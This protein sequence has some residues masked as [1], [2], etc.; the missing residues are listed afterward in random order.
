MR[1]SS[2]RVS[3]ESAS[4]AVLTYSFE[5]LEHPEAETPRGVEE[6]EACT[7]RDV[8]DPGLDGRLEQ[9]PCRLGRLDVSVSRASGFGG[10]VFLV[11]REQRR[12]YSVG[13]VVDPEVAQSG[14]RH[15]FGTNLQFVVG[16]DKLV[17]DGGVGIARHGQN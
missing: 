14:A 5:R 4:P 17:E 12:G 16:A 2:L 11:G 15:A 6:T 9:G 3:A 13:H 1:R 10:E 7:P 8:L